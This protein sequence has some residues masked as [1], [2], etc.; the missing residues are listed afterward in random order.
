MSYSLPERPLDPPEDTRRKVYTCEICGDPILEY[1]EYYDI[2]D[3]G[4]CHANCVG[5]C[6]HYEAELD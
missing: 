3:Y 5:D 1:D 2:P 6:Y 4:Q